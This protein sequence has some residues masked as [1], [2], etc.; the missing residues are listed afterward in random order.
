MPIF[1]PFVVPIGLGVV[2]GWGKWLVGVSEV[3]SWAE[4]SEDSEEV[5]E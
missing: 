2:A 3:F 1:G 4:S 5:E